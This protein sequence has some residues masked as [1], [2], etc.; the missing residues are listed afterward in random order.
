MSNKTGCQLYTGTSISLSTNTNAPLY[1]VIASI[2]E[3]GTKV[4]ENFKEPITKKRI[5]KLVEVEVR[6]GQLQ[7][8]EPIKSLYTCI[9][10]VCFI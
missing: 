5:N 7:I 9:S 1:N 2:K 10:I 6:N 3:R 4:E 8:T